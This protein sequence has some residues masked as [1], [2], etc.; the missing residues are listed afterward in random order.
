M[1]YD[2]HPIKSTTTLSNAFSTTNGSST[3]TITFSGDH[4]INESD[5]VLLDNFSS[6]T[7]SNFGASDFDDKKFMVTTVPSST[8]IT[9]T[10]PSNETGSGA[11]T[12]GGIRVQHY[13]TVGPA[14]Q[15][16]GFGWS[17]G[18]WGGEEVGAFTTTL[19]G[20][21]NDSVTTGITLVDPSQFPDSGTC[22]LYTSD[23]ADE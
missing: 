20:A 7:N 2:I 22:L 8:T 12:S 16:K 17:L 9:I 18:T 19:S 13:Y 3:V 6:I 4:G 15:A 5:I 14:V 21:I 11:T 23:A 1:F 10:M